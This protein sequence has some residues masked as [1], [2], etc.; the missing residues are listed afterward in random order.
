MLRVSISSKRQQDHQALLASYS[1]N[2]LAGKVGSTYS[3]VLLPL[4]CFKC[5]W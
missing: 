2:F 5:I 1:R 3:T 4:T